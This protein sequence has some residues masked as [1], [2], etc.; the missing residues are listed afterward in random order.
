MT[1]WPFIISDLRA[2]ARWLYGDDKPK[3]ML[4]T[5]FTDGTFAMLAYRHM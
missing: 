3:A 4:K 5:V 2:K 1:L